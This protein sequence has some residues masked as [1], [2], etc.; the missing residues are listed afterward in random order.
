MNLHA[1]KKKAPRILGP[2]FSVLVHVGLVALLLHTIG[3]APKPKQEAVTFE[4][5]EMPEVVL[6]DVLPV[7]L[8]PEPPRDAL[9]P[10]PLSA[11][12][13]AAMTPD[14]ALDVTDTSFDLSALDNLSP[15]TIQ[16]VGADLGSRGVLSERYGKRAVKN[17]LLGSYFNQVDFT[18]ETFMR[19]DETLNYV[20]DMD[21][22][23]TERVRDDL[24]SIIWTGR[25]VPPRTGVYTFYLQSDDGARLWIDGALVLDQFVERSRATDE[26][27][28]RLLVGKSYDI[29]YAFCEVF[30]HAVSSLEWSCEEAGI[31]RQLIPT[32]HLWADGPSTRQ[33]IAWNEEVGRGASVRYPNRAKMR[34]PAM[35]EG[36]AFSHLVGFRAL[37]EAGLTR[38]GLEELLPEFRD[39]RR[40]GR[41]PDTARLPALPDGIEQ[42]AEPVTTGQ[43]VIINVL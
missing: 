4:I 17:G 39:Y 11:E 14:D 12:E 27:Q 15:L 34:N 5:T 30:R 23:W 6:D 35:I 13:L 36:E 8:V 37:D 16:G 2:V 1:L 32:E 42:H 18:G 26:V 20:W 28:V 43:D 10:E 38:L 29:K 40:S 3:F 21:S 22:P 25:I 24:F 19:I 9:N 33:L 7:D 41:V 31:P